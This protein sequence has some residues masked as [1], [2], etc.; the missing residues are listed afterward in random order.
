MTEKERETY[1]LALRATGLEA[2]SAERAGCTMTAVR[3]EYESDPA[4][5]EAC[6]DTIALRA[7]EFE[8]EAI[9]RAVEGYEEPVYYQGGVVGHVTKYSDSLLSKILTAR[10]PK[11]YGE[12]KQI[13][14][15]NDGPLKIIINEFDDIL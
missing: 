3:R 6:N 12:K 1:M 5:E 14:G 10:K 7:D 11:L 8:Q 4:F 2:L 13:T 15:A 9:R